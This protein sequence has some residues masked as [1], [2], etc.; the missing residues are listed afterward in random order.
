MPANSVPPTTITDQRQYYNARWAAFQYPDALEVVRLH[1]MLGL[2]CRIERVRKICDLG[3]GSGWLA[4]ILGHLAP[5]VGVD[6]GDVSR[7]K[8][9]YPHCEFVSA[10]ILNWDH[11]QA[12]FDL[13]VSSEVLEHIPYNGQSRYLQI[14]CDL[15]EP[16]GSLILTTP[17][18]AT[19][20]AMPGGGRTYSNQPIEDWVD[21]ERL[22]R[23]LM[24]A[25]FSVTHATSFPLGFGQLGKHR[26][27]NSVK[28][29]RLLGALGLGETWRRYALRS[30]FGL[31]LAVLARKSRSAR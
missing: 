1:E 16:G 23:L 30:D 9:R 13:V 27:V 3:C 8:E 14:A 6:L 22:T 24:D 2:L 31:H 12:A 10:D 4:G 26:M 7:A 21:R 11:P 18:K 29:Q 17:N 25:G 15:L 28:L 19:M 5:T 20:D